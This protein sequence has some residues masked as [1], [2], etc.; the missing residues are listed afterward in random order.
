M[1]VAPVGSSWWERSARLV[2]PARVTM[3]SGSARRWAIRVEAELRRRSRSAGSSWRP[4]DGLGGQDNDGVEAAEPFEEGGGVAEAEGGEL[5]DQQQGFLPGRL[6]CRAVVDEVLEEVAGEAGGVVAEGQ[7][8][9]EEVGGAGVL[10][11]PLP[12]QAAA[13][14][15]GE[16]SVAGYRALTDSRINVGCVAQSR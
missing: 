11:G 16:G 9:E 15:G 14:G 5:V 7:A 13:D 10:E 2:V 12:H 6:P 1:P 3:G 8:V 4:S